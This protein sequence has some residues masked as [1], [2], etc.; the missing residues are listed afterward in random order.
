MNKM[1]NLIRKSAALLALLS[2][3]C[4]GCASGDPG[5]TEASAASLPQEIVGNT[6]IPETEPQAPAQTETQPRDVLEILAVEDQGEYVQLTTSYCTLRYAFAISDLMQVRCGGEPGAESL[7]FLAELEQR[8]YPLFCLYFGE[9]RGFRL[10]SLEL[11]VTGETVAVWAELLEL[12]GEM[13]EGDRDAAIA[14][15]EC[16]NDVIA[17][18][19][20]N[21]NFTP[22]E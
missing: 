2:L 15:Q 10:G 3:L 18:L 9:G 13:P 11:P 19:G 7:L 4:A 8:E 14:C 22:A 5:Q 16:I 17:A 6:E 21:G 20:E 12:D 1:K